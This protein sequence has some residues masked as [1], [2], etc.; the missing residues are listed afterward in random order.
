MRK[1]YAS[2]LLISVVAIG[3]LATTPAPE[4]L[5]SHFSHDTR[6]DYRSRLG[7]PS[8][9]ARD[10][11]VPQSLRLH[12]TDL[13]GLNQTLDAPDRDFKQSENK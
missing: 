3:E 1:G 6:L 11:L 8:F 4:L 10:S 12:E 9:W 13:P 2:G 7:P 5:R